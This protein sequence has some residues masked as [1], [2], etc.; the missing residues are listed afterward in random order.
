MEGDL[1]GWFLG[2]A[3]L[4]KSSNE[5]TKKRSIEKAVRDGVFSGATNH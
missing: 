3:A 2:S 5:G 4:V 1:T